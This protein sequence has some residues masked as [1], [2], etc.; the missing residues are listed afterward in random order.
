MNILELESV[1]SGYNRTIIIRDITLSVPQGSITSILGRNGVGK[2][3]LLKTIMGLVRIE[4]GEMRYRGSSL[5]GLKPFEIAN[6]GIAYTPQ[7][8]ENSI[9]PD[10]T[11]SENLA[12]G[13]QPKFFRAAIK[14]TLEYFPQLQSRQ[15]Q[16]A[17]TLSGGEKKMV[18]LCRT[19]IRDP[20]LMFLD[21]I[22]EGLQPS[23][24]LKVEEILSTIN[25]EKK[26]TV[27]VVEQNVKFSLKVAKYYVIMNQGR[28]VENGAIGEGA[29]ETIEKHLVI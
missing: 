12:I 9:F 25:K 29:K 8:E 1:C 28:I 23:M 22:S 15:K 17:G 18:I 21:E 11:V 2:S 19:M 10:L 4:R 24:I 5:I 6:A 3:T 20:Q 13:L 16:K 27:V 7:E 26:T 14:A